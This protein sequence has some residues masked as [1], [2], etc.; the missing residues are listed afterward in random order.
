MIFHWDCSVPMPIC[1]PTSRRYWN[2]GFQARQCPLWIHTLKSLLLMG[3]YFQIAASIVASL[4]DCSILLYL[5]QISLLLSTNLA[6]LCHGLECHISSSSSS[7]NIKG[8]PGQGLFF[9]ATSVLNLHA[10]SDANWHVWPIA[11]LSLA[12][13][14]SL[15]IL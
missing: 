6:N 12:S 3:I 7:T 8:R 9:L 15:A 11:S 13:A 14:S 2:F 5:A 10:F 4:V 1:S